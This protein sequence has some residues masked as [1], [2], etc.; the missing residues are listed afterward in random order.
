MF[1][2]VLFIIGNWIIQ[3]LYKSNSQWSFYCKEYS[4]AIKSPLEEFYSVTGQV[5]YD[6]LSYK[7]QIVFQR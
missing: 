3:E 6:M 2:I 4:E 1:I 7:E 5:V